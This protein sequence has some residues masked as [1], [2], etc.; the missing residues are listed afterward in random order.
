MEGV[1]LAKSKYLSKAHPTV[2]TVSKSVLGSIYADTIAG[3]A[4]E[5]YLDFAQLTS[6]TSPTS[7]SSRIYR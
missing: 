2:T 5:A 1:T 7:F 6:S 3:G 4:F